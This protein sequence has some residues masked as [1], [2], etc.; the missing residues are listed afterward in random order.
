MI[1]ERS[2]YF[3]GIL[4]VG[5]A[6]TPRPEDD[7]Y[8][9]PQSR[10]YFDL[11]MAAIDIPA[12]AA[13]G[14]GSAHLAEFQRKG[15][16]LSYLSEC[17]LPSDPSEIARAISALSPA[18]LRRIRFNYKPKHIALLS[19]GMSPLIDFLERSGLGPLLLRDREGSA[20]F[21]VTAGLPPGS[22]LRTALRTALSTGA[23]PKNDLSDYDR[24]QSN[25]A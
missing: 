4:F 2:S 20:S 11:L 19:A 1:G 17:P 10:E 5:L 16:Y 9:P 12:S 15:C 7:F 21:S 25:Q 23:T 22:G 14:D 6:P 18:L 8:G 24:M 13:A 3:A